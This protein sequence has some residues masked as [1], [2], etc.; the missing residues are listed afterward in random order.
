MEKQS[1]EVPI[2]GSSAKSGLDV[3]IV[4]QKLSASFNTADHS[5]NT[6]PIHSIQLIP[7]NTSLQFFPD[8][9]KVLE[10]GGDELI[11]SNNNGEPVSQPVAEDHTEIPIADSLVEN[12]IIE[13][14][15]DTIEKSASFLDTA[16]SFIGK[17]IFSVG[18]TGKS[19]VHE[20]IEKQ[21]FEVIS[22][23]SN[24][25]IQFKDY[26]EW[27]IC[28]IKGLAFQRFKCAQCD[29]PIG[30]GMFMEARLC[31]ISGYY[32]CSHCH[33][34]DMCTSPARIINN[35]DFQPVKVAKSVLRHVEE[36]KSLPVIDL[37]KRNSVIFQLVPELQKVKNLREELLVTKDFIMT[38][39]T[40]TRHELLKMIWP[41]EH[42]F[43]NTNMY[44]V[45]DLE[46]VFKET[47][48][49]FLGNVVSAFKKH[50]LYECEVNIS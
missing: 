28:P 31:D 27:N 45:E 1:E 16:I 44:S 33:L 14:H 8:D 6:N 34:N 9:T 35:W 37:E 46:D 43:N 21:K 42:L 19:Q 48:S 50:I 10:V 2:F 13:N 17:S 36:T 32:F 41:R 26:I 25:P 20:P 39:K 24:S 12:P 38:C 30:M 18:E 49:V 47:L 7:E 4:F 23:H 22:S 11:N 15:S 3:D 40:E 29:K 5:L